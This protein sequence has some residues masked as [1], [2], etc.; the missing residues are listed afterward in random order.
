LAWVFSPRLQVMSRRHGRFRR[1]AVRLVAGAMGRWS[2]PV[3]D[4][5]TAIRSR[6]AISSADPVGLRSLLSVGFRWSMKGGR[7][8]RASPGGWSI[9]MII[10]KDLEKLIEELRVAGAL[11]RG[12]IASGGRRSPNP[13]RGS[14]RKYH[15]TVRARKG[16]AVRVSVL[17][18]A[19]WYMP[20]AQFWETPS[21]RPTKSATTRMSSPTSKGFAK[22]A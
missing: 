2:G 8:A 21:Y 22:W 9:F 14:I 15:R 3:G 5:R 7:W 17:W 18:A 16:P 1:R 6:S 12:E 4:S 13:S 19:A 20:R 10:T 11:F